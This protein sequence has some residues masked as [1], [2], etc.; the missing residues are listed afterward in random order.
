MNKITQVVFSAMKKLKNDVMIVNVVGGGQYQLDRKVKGG[1]SESRIFDLRLRGG[2]RHS[3]V[4]RES[5][6]GREN[7]NYKSQ[8]R[9]RL[10]RIRDWVGQLVGMCKR[11]VMVSPDNNVD[12][13]NVLQG[14]SWTRK[15]YDLQN[16]TDKLFKSGK[17]NAVL[18]WH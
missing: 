13:L 17:N 12:L 2:V 10:G 14:F 6:P 9:Y 16:I 4:C 8:G 7:S 11:K 3:N 18:K 15:M 5:I 1:L